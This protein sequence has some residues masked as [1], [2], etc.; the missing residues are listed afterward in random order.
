MKAEDT[1][2]KLREILIKY[3]NPEYGDCIV[4]EICQLFKYPTT[5]D[6]EKPKFILGEDRINGIKIND[7]I[8]DEELF[9]YEIRDKEDFIAELINW[10]SEASRD[11]QMMIDDLKILIA[12]D[13][14]YI[15][16][17]NKTNDYI[18]QGHADFES[19]CKELLELNETFN[20]DANE[21]N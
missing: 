12:I 16:S 6:I 17:S 15:F 20:L 4:D 21:K 19:T 14:D 3:N 7:K 11:K 9:E 8:R 18:Y 5:I 13:N 10:I 1:H 2:D